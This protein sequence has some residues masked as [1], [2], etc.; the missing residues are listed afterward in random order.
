ME[1]VPRFPIGGARE[2]GT[3]PGKIKAVDAHPRRVK[4]IEI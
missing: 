4:S 3:W 2:P 1:A